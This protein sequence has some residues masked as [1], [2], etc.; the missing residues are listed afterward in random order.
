MDEVNN[1]FLYMLQKDGMI[2]YKSDNKKTTI[3]IVN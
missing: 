2:I 3:T 1:L